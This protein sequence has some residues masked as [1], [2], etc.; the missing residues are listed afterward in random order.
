MAY[1]VNRLGTWT[2]HWIGVVGV[3][4]FF[5]HTS[6]VLMWSLERKPHTLDF[7][8]RRVFRIYPLAILITLTAITLHAPVSAGTTNQFTYRPPANANELLSAL[9]LIPNLSRNYLAV[10][11]MWSLPYEV[12]MYLVLPLIFFFVRQNFSPWPLLFF[13]GFIVVVCRTLFPGVAH[14]FFLCIPYFLPGVIAYVGFGR[15]KPFLPAWVLPFAVAGAW[16]WFMHHPDWRRANLLCLSIGLL[17]PLFHQLRARALVRASHLTAKYSYGAYLTHPF[18]IVLGLYCMPHAP[19][20]VQLL[21]IVI[22]TAVFSV[23]AYHLVEHPLI[24]LGSRLA[25]RAETRY[26]QHELATF[27]IAESVIP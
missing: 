22:G 26:E 23:A 15:W 24:R 12:Q 7:Y 5:V 8:I 16:F 25:N 20:A 6:L 13:W 11:V 27:R 14:N 17:L 9:L 21:T 18:A 2:T 1:N 10:G 3:F 19:L 4:V